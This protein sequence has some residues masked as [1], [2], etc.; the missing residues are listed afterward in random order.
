MY[1]DFRFPAW[2]IAVHL[3]VAGDVFDGVFLWCPFSREMSWMRSG[4][5]LSKFLRVFLPTL[6]FFKLIYYTVPLLQHP[7][8]FDGN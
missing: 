4:T 2:E 1:K 7:K 3:A 5:L 6:D 8:E